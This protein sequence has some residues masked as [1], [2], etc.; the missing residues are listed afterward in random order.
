MKVSSMLV[1]SVTIKLHIRVIWQLIFNL[2]MKV[3]S[4]L[5][6]SVTIKLQDSITWKLI[7]NLN[8]KVF[9]ENICKVI[10]YF[11]SCYASCWIN[12]FHQLWAESP[13]GCEV[14]CFQCGDNDPVSIFT[15]DNWY[16]ASPYK[17]TGNFGKM[18][19]R[20]ANIFPTL[21]GVSPTAAASLS[22]T[23]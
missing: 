2:N 11:F 19:V 1:I 21:C 12:Q 17:Y 4:M 3:S 13:V 23:L 6:T 16:P 8:I 18:I 7:F 5:V 14:S 15:A 22:P 9:S 10:N 20:A